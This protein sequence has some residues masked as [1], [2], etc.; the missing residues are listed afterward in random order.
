MVATQTRKDAYFRTGSGDDGNGL[1]VAPGGFVTVN[2]S[3]SWKP[4]PNLTLTAG[5]ENV[6]DQG[7]AEFI[8]RNDIDDPF[9]FNPVAAGRSFYVRGSARF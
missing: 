7:Y 2:L 5:I 9:M 8:D 1:G 3:L 6:F 4:R